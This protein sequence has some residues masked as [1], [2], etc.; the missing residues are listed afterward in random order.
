MGW[1]KATGIGVMVS[2]IVFMLLQVMGWAVKLWHPTVATSNDMTQQIVSAIKTGPW[3]QG[4]IFIVCSGVLAP[5]VEELVF[6]GVIA[7][8]WLRL[9]TSNRG[10]WLAILGSG[11]LF[12]S[13]HFLSAGFSLDPSVILTILITWL[14][15]SVLA[16]MMDRYDSIWPGVIAHVVYNTAGLMIAILV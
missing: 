11:S 13:A 8:S 10:R 7:R 2:V 5:I 14:L 15:G 9:A 12:A 3:Y 16:W 1:L 6:R 4:L